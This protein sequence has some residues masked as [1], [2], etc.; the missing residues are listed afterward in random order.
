MAKEDLSLTY[1]ENID[2][3]H[4]KTIDA[5]LVTAPSFV[6]AYRNYLLSD[7]E[8]STELAYIRDVI[9]YL[10]YLSARVPEM[11][12]KEFS[13]FP[14]EI[15]DRL[16]LNDMDEYKEYLLSEKELQGS[17]AKKKLAAVAS[18][19]NYLYANK[20]ISSNPMEFFRFP[21]I[22]KK[23]VIF[24]NSKYSTQL[25]NGILDNN[26]FL[27]QDGTGDVIEIPNKVRLKREKLVLRNYA[28]CYLFLGTGLRVSELVGLDIDDVHFRDRDEF[29]GT[30]FVRVVVKG[31]D[32]H[33]VFFSDEVADAL[34]KYI[35]GPSS[36]SLSEKFPANSE[37]SKKAQLY[38][39]NSL[40]GDKLD[41]RIHIDFPDATS[42]DAA[43]I[44]RLTEFFRRSGRAGFRPD[45]NNKAL[46][47]S[48]R[49]SRMTVRMV[50]LMLKEMARTYIPE[51]QNVDDFSPHKLRATCATRIL[52][53]TRNLKLAQE[54]LNHGNIEVTARYYT[55]IKN[56]ER[57]QA[58][59]DL[60][61]KNW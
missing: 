25:L 31:G 8:T 45:S 36:P 54:Q 4:K 52:K 5:L 19:I 49:G 26:K 27:M 43:E 39:S 18:F 14:V 44:R 29:N 28:I 3:Q 15:L 24:L 7:T 51:F 38:A 13:D 11:K 47:L 1:R 53:Q 17:S 2:K 12:N 30:N 57:A 37:E 35:K 60:D 46:F 58:L 22:K 21:T 56:E 20:V 34:L 55:A 48:N 10:M 16:T 59:K 32:E 61:I 42:E 41:K 6:G 40:D 9:D 23:E 33:D 50:E